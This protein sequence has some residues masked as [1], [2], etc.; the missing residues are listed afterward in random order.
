MDSFLKGNN[1]YAIGL[2]Y[3][4]ADVTVRS[5]FSLS[6]EQQISLLEEA[7]LAGFEEL[8]VISTCNR[9]EIIGFAKHPYELISQLCKYSEGTV[10]EFA[11]YSFVYKNME[12]AEHFISVAT[13]LDSQILGDYEIVN[14]LK[15]SYDIAKNAGTMSAYMERLYNTAL[16]ASKEVKNKTQLSSGTTTVSYATVQYIRERA[17]KYPNPK[18][19]LFGLGEIGENTAKG[20]KNHVEYTSLTVVNRTIEK[21]HVLRKNLGVELASIDNLEDE[22]KKADVIIL[23]TGAQTHTVKSSMFDPD[24]KQLIIDLSIPN[25]VDQKIREFT[26]KRVVDVDKL[27]AKTKSTFENRKLQI[28]KVL[29]IIQKYKDEFYNSVSFR[30]SSP[31]LNSLKIS[32]ESIQRDAIA[33]NQ[34]KFEQFSPSEIEEVTTTMINKIISKFASHMREHNGQADLSIQ[35]IEQVFK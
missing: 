19:L 16:Q 3:K 11:R 15:S 13:G 9:T 31:A 25:N 21:S 10:D 26:N 30:K 6:K 32:L 28:P 5:K 33:V 1:F 29:E 4:K 34:K 22:I 7:R 8:M 14:Q 12:A 35:V 2:S 27:S 20:L 18:I 17:E 23:A 24:K